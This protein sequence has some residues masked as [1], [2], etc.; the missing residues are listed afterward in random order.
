[1]VFGWKL[2]ATV[3]CSSAY[4]W[5]HPRQ[6]PGM[7]AVAPGI[8]WA[9]GGWRSATRGIRPCPGIHSFHT[10]QTRSHETPRP[11]SRAVAAAPPC[12][13]AVEAGLRSPPAAR[14]CSFQ[15]ILHVSAGG[16]G[17][18]C[19][20][21]RA[22]LHPS[23]QRPLFCMRI[24]LVLISESDKRGCAGWG[25]DRVVLLPPRPCLQGAQEPRFPVTEASDSVPPNIIASAAPS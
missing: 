7:Q 8:V 12:V 11:P 13:A 24:T 1:M 20:K 19:R 4:L 16:R 17:A 10:L 23:G 14:Y 9:G 6:L 5:W 15:T 3:V 22:G 25:R 2:E 21:A 18:A